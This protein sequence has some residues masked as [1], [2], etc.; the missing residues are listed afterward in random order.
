MNQRGGLER[1]PGRF[2]R[3]LLDRQQAEFIVDQGQQFIQRPGISLAL[4]ACRIRV[5][6][7]ISGFIWHRNSVPWQRLPSGGVRVRYPL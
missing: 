6:S 2:V 3:Q 1:L 5:T 4:S 7:V